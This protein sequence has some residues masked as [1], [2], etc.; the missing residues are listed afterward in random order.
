MI[1]VPSRSMEAPTEGA[2]MYVR[3]ARHIRPGISVS[4][5]KAEPNEIVQKV[6]R[7][8]HKRGLL[9]LGSFRPRVLP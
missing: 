9:S 1:F 6:A 8:S 7:L 2:A 3:L 4:L 5:L